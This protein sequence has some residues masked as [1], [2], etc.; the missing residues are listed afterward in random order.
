MAFFANNGTFYKEYKDFE[1]IGPLIYSVAYARGRLYLINNQSYKIHVQGF[2]LDVNS[3]NIL[4]S[5]RPGQDMD[6][7]HD[8]AV[9][10]D[11]SEIY[12]VELNKNTVY[13]FLQSKIFKFLRYKNK[14]YLICISLNNH[15]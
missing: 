12:V 7:P 5:F 4:F 6:S 8:I 14:A 13:K 3:G 9:S 11:G 15:I 10:E 1:R 2:V